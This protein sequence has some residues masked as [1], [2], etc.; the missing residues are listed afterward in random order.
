MGLKRASKQ[1]TVPR[2]TIQ[3]RSRVRGGANKT[4]KKG[5]GGLKRVFNEA[6]ENEIVQHVKFM[7]GMLLGFTRTQ[8]RRLAF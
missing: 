8:L 3:R 4:V 5:L 6:M 7:E 1:C 2:T